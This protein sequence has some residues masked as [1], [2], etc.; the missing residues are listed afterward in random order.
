MLQSQ[1]GYVLLLG[2]T[3]TFFVESSEF[4]RDEKN[5]TNIEMLAVGDSR[6]DS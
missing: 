3:Q 4:L 1:V 2:A 6:A 5:Y